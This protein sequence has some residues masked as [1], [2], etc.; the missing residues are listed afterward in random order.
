M[1]WGQALILFLGI[2][3]IVTV[4]A[5]GVMSTLAVDVFVRDSEQDDDR[6]INFIVSSA[7]G[8]K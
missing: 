2:S 7:E 4:V 8:V 6:D 1:T 3:S 5:M